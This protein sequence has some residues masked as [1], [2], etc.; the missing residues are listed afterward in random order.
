EF[1]IKYSET[2][3]VAKVIAEVARQK[4]I[5]QI[6]IGQTAKSRWQEITKGS[7]INVLMHHIPFVDLHLVSVSRELKN[8]EGFFE[9]G[10]RAYLI[11]EDS[12]YKLSFTH[13]HDIAHEGIFFKELGTD[14][15]NGVFKYMHDNQMLEVQVVD[16]FIKLDIPKEA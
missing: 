3:P 14:F 15:N 16:D 10:I 5:T 12:G 2:R 4:H 7:F 13:T 9:K 11:A 6:V 1:I 8:R